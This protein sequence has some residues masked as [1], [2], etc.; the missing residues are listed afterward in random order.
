MV[1]GSW[2]EIFGGSLGPMFRDKLFCLYRLIC[3]LEEWRRSNRVRS[4]CLDRG[5]LVVSVLVRLLP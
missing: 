3:R 2:G 5:I 4:N 1:V